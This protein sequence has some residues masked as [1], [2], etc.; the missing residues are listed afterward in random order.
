MRENT[1]D[2]QAEQAGP[3]AQGREAAWWSLVMGAAAA[4]EDA[5]HC[6]RDPD[7][8]RKADG[9]AAHYRAAAQ[10]LYAAPPAAPQPQ[11]SPP[12]PLT[13]SALPPAYMLAKLQMVM[14]LLQEARDALTAITETQRKLYGISASLA[15][16]MDEAGTYNLD[17]WKR[18][19]GI[20]AQENRPFLGA[21]YVEG[22]GYVSTRCSTERGIGTQEGGAL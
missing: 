20:G 5:S 10:Q 16:R 11:A 2:E 8:K 14:P 12:V 3:V 21:T 19:H 4:I 15:D 9:D 7:A 18:A 17:D 13:D 22:H 1:R 6:L